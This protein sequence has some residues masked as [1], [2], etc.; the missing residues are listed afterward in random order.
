MLKK[1]FEQDTPGWIPGFYSPFAV[2]YFFIICIILLS[3]HIFYPNDL[4]YFLL[5]TCA[6]QQ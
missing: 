4:C 5:G 3:M 1:L 2:D 6:L